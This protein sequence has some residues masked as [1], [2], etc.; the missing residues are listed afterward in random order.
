MGYV[1]DISSRL[2]G[3]AAV[4]WEAKIMLPAVYGRRCPPPPHSCL[5]S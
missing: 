5:W 3:E 4:L 2:S 1:P